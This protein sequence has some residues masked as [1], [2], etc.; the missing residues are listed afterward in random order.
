MGLGVE[1]AGESP[2]VGFCRRVS[3]RRLGAEVALPGE[4]SGQ[5]RVEAREG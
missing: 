5:P 1:A 3:G 4:C 2:V